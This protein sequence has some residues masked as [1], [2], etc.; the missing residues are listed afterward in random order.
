MSDL[1]F[2]FRL[3]ETLGPSRADIILV[4]G[5]AHRLMSLHPLATR[6]IEALTTRDVDLLIEPG[7]DGLA[8]RLQSA[9]FEQHMKMGDERPP[10]SHYQQKDNPGW[11][12]EHPARTLTPH[13][14]SAA[15]CLA[16]MII[17]EITSVLT[18]MTAATDAV[19]GAVQVARST[20][21]PNAPL[22][23]QISATLTGALRRYL[24]L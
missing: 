5:W 10:V 1:D 17:K 21:R 14:V 20:G 15:S 19:L 23:G 6:A 9:G 11:F 22:P 8:A 7:A 18:E 16:K 2:I 12:R 3:A 4:G 24:S 13:R